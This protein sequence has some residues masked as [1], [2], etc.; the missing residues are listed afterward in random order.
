MDRHGQA[1]MGEASCV[2]HTNTAVV[3]AALPAPN[4]VT[5]VIPSFANYSNVSASWASRNLTIGVQPDRCVMCVSL[6]PNTKP[7][8]LDLTTTCPVF[9]GA[10]HVWAAKRLVR[11]SP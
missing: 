3:G 4:M 8:T 5:G 7:V 2:S 6:L 11:C 9:A 10:R 1:C